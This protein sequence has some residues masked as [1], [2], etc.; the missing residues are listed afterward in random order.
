MVL[1]QETKTG[2]CERMAEKEVLRE[3]MVVVDHNFPAHSQP[4]GKYT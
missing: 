3:E 4:F 2:N 1:P